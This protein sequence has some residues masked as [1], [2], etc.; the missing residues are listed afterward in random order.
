MLFFP[1]RNGGVTCESE[2]LIPATSTGIKPGLDNRTTK[3]T[4]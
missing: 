3:L 1:G 4:I 2:S